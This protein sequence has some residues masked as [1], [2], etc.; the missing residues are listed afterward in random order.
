LARPRVSA[1]RGHPHRA[2]VLR[3]ERATTIAREVPGP[4]FGRG[5]G[6]SPSGATSSVA[7]AHWA[8]R[9]ESDSVYHRGS[10]RWVWEK[11]RQA[12]RKD[13]S[14]LS[15]PGSNRHGRAASGD[16]QTQ[17][18]DPEHLS[19]TT[20]TPRRPPGFLGCFERHARLAPCQYG[21][22][23]WLLPLIMVL[24]VLAAA[25]APAAVSAALGVVV[26]AV[27]GFVGVPRYYRHSQR[28]NQA[29]R[30]RR[31]ARAT[32]SSSR[33]ICSVAVVGGAVPAVARSLG[34]CAVPDRPAHAE[35][36]R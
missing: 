15:T 11:G 25:F 30:Q 7:L 19:S 35:S 20:F 31:L 24:A 36:V 6:A 9:W 18:R 12:A 17:E 10:A 29:G 2:S 21:V 14:R 32:G 28:R 8:T 5:A 27:L 16:E 13:D 33:S 34:P 3:W 1:E 26:F 22:A 4:G 23:P